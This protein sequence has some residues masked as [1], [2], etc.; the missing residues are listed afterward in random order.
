MQRHIGL[1]WIVLCLSAILLAT[2]TP[3]SLPALAQARQVSP[4]RPI[5]AFYYPWYELSDWSYTRMSD[6]PTPRYSG[7]KRRPS[8]DIFSRLSKLELTHSYVHGMDQMNPASM[9]VA[10][11]SKTSPLKWEV[12]SRL[13]FFR[14]NRHGNRSKREISWWLPLLC[15]NATL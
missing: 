7:G 6:L 3:P 11:G 13:P 1:T 2:A 9:L 12:R 10:V 4:D 5:M 8:A 14:S 15:L